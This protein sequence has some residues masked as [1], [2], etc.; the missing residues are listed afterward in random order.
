MGITDTRPLTHVMFSR[1]KGHNEGRTLVHF[2]RGRTR[3]PL[4]VSVAA[5]IGIEGISL[6]VT[7]S[8]EGLARLEYWLSR[9]AELSRSWAT[10]HTLN[11]TYTVKQGEPTL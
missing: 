5:G 3:A 8:N 7:P 11:V 9:N 2:Y 4:M 6:V 10:E 1:I